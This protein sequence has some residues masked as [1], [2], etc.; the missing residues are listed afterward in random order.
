MG[1][2]RDQIDSIITDVDAKLIQVA[3]RA[4]AEVK[5]LEAK[6]AVLLTAKALVTDEAE[7]AIAGL[8]RLGVEL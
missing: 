3:A 2:I 1:A 4:A 6:K 8:K 5:S 7:A